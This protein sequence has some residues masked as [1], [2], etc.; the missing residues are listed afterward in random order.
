MPRVH[1]TCPLWPGSAGK[2]LS[3][4]QLVSEKLELRMLLSL[5][6]FWK[7]SLWVIYSFPQNP[8]TETKLRREAWLRHNTAA[9]R[10]CHLSRTISPR[11]KWLQSIIY[12]YASCAL[13]KSEGTRRERYPQL[14]A[15]RSPRNWLYAVALNLWFLFWLKV[16][17]AFSFLFLF[18]NVLRY[19][20]PIKIIDT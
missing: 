9:R 5:S 4:A 15:L 18:P 16:P 2:L 11:K 8:V 6:R 7:P 12:S 20:W 17:N 13:H 3:V 19:N 10:P 1:V 14:S